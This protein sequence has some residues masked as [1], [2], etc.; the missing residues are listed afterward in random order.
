MDSGMKQITAAELEASGGDPFESLL[1]LEDRFLASGFA[2]GARAPPSAGAQPESVQQLTL[3]A[4]MRTQVSCTVARRVRRLAGSSDTKR[5]TSLAV[6]LE[7]TEDVSTPCLP[8][9][10]PIPAS[11]PIGAPTPI[12]T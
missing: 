5:A 1:T 3:P 6:S 10:R 7:S 8:F 11:L 4:D 2:A 12:A 9:Q